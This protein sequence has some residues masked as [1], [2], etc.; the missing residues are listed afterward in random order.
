MRNLEE[1]RTIDFNSFLIHFGYELGLLKERGIKYA[2]LNHDQDSIWLTPGDEIDIENITDFGF[3]T[4]KLLDEAT[5]LYRDMDHEFK[6]FYLDLAVISFLR[7]RPGEPDPNL[8]TKII[9]QGMLDPIQV[10]TPKGN[11]HNLR[12]EDLT[13]DPDHLPVLDAILGY[14]RLYPQSASDRYPYGVPCK[15]KKKDPNAESNQTSTEENSFSD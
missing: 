11:P 7:P 2:D 13:V 4:T 12:V 3:F 8:I 1:E 15:I 6:L 14:H 10:Y 5:S 9:F